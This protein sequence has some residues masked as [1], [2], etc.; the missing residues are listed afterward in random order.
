MA[1][2]TQSNI[3]VQ[4]EK[5]TVIISKE[6][7][8]PGYEKAL[9]TYA[10]QA[11]I[12][13]FRKG[14]VPAAVVKKMY[15]DS[16]FN[17]EVLRTAGE[18]MDNYVK[19]NNLKLFVRPLP[20]D[21]G[22]G[23]KFDQN[24]PSDY[25]FDFEMGLQPEFNIP[26]LETRKK[27]DAF[28]V[29]VT[30]E[31]IDEEVDK[32]AYRAGKMTEPEVVGHEDDVLNVTFEPCDENGIV[33]EDANKK[34]NSLLV[35]YFIANWQKEFMGK[36]N[37]DAVHFTLGNAI[38]EKLLPAL[39]KDLGLAVGADD[40]KNIFFKMT[41][42]KIGHVDKAAIEAGLFE[43]IYPGQ[44]IETETDFRAKIKEEIGVYWESQGRNKLHNELYETLIHETPITLPTE[45]LK[46]W[47][48]L[49]SETPKTKEQVEQE[50]PGFEHSLRWQ[51]VSDR[52]VADN[53]MNVSREELEEATRHSVRSYFAQMGMPNAG[54]SEEDAPWMAGIVEKQLKDKKFVGDTYN[55]I[56]TDKIFMWLEHQIE[57]N[58]NELPLDEFI[59]LPSSHHHH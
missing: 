39:E 58:M 21:N 40:N 52:I 47:M 18:A 9:K 17:D 38:D 1:T 35:K 10:K 12:P 13:G 5:V 3:G 48:E 31:M 44:G 59:K 45:F 30:E 2:I 42:D 53:K 56:M 11:N 46:R 24:A 27:L 8:L 6:D 26:L 23:Y 49:D 29:I 55:K 34:T 7:Y 15:G 54:A 37:G 14:M 16:V 20:M 33:A 19:Q 36:I 41:I 43:D 4:H 50:W 32:M 28:K 51:L 22:M 25:T 57:I